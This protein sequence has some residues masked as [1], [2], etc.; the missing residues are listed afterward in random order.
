MKSLMKNRNITVFLYVFFGFFLV[1][2]GSVSWVF[3]LAE[4]GTAWSFDL[5]STIIAY[6]FQTVGI[7]IFTLLVRLHKSP[8]QKKTFVMAIYILYV[9]FLFP[10]MFAAYITGTFLFGFVMNL[11]GGMIE[12]GFLHALSYMVDYRKRGLVFGGAG[13]AATLLIG[14]I[15]LIAGGAF[16]KSTFSILVYAPIAVILYFLS[17]HGEQEIHVIREN[18]NNPG[19]AGVK[20]KYIPALLLACATVTLSGLVREIVLYYPN[21]ESGQEN[22]PRALLFFYA[23]GLLLAGILSDLNRKFGLAGAFIS[24]VLPFLMKLPVCKSLPEIL[25]SGPDKFFYGF[26]IVF[27]VLLFA[28]LCLPRKTETQT[29]NEKKKNER[30]DILKTAGFAFGFGFLFGRLGEAVGTLFRILLADRGIVL[31]CLV[32][33]FFVILLILYFRLFFSKQKENL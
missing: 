26:L 9:F 33:V 21:A 23:T 16:F 18:V 31:Y 27:S 20:T 1:S 28:D 25:K 13:F 5:V 10:S 8:V 2:A 4:I 24:V 6:L 29:E 7:T 22:G 17:V 3:H 14:L 11:L 30:G 19:T 15:L 32:G 12:G